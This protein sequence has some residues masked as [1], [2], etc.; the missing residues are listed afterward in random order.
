MSVPGKRRTK[1]LPAQVATQS[2]I[3][4]SNVRYA[5]IRE[6]R[7]QGVHG[8]KDS[9]LAASARRAAAGAASDPTDWRLRHTSKQCQR[10]LA[11]LP[12]RMDLRPR[13]GHVPGPAVILVHCT[14]ELNTRYH[15]IMDRIGAA[16]DRSAPE[17]TS[18]RFRD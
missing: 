13:G 11:R 5:L 4:E 18:D 12:F 16:P 14:P 6:H 10:F 8:K 3:T 15:A 2:P 17:S 9:K 1:V 7:I